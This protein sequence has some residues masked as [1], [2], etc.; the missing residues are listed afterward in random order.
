MRTQH[1]PV[2]L[3]GLLIALLGA[4]LGGA[5]QAADASRIGRPA[6]EFSAVDSHG[7]TVS[8]SD[9]RGKLVVL[10]WTN[11]GCPF[12]QHYYKQG[13]MQALQ[14]EYTGKGVVWL[15]VISSAPGTQGYADGA[16]ADR[17][18]KLR[19]AAPSAVL[20]DPSGKLGHLYDAKTTPDMFIVDGYGKLIY[21]GGIDSLPSTDPADIGRASPYVKT[22]LDEALAGKAVS[23][24][25]T[26]P[27]GCSVKYE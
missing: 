8:L 27:Y 7:K 14:K 13:N 5:A 24:P 9:Y 10:E 1:K 15:S 18:T 2:V 26:S 6:P 16:R 19:G 22:A 17:L 23:K 11:D 12:V 20:L 25:L 3:S 4:I 21:A